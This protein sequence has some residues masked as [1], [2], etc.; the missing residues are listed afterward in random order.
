ML[1]ARW[2]SAL[3]GV[4]RGS[5]RS[6]P[7]S[8]GPALDAGLL[9]AVLPLVPG[10]RERL[11]AG[12][13][14]ADVGCGCGHALNLMA[15]AFPASRF[16]GWDVSDEALT[17]GRAEAERKGLANVRFEQR[18]A[19]TLGVSESFDF[20]TTFDAIHDQARPDL[21]LRR[22]W[23]GP[24]AREVLT[25]AWRSV[26][27]ARWLTTSACPGLP[28]MYAL[29]CMHCMTVSL[30]SG[31][32]GLGGHVGRTVGPPPSR[33]GR[34]AGAG[35]QA[36]PVRPFQQLLHC[37]QGHVGSGAQAGLEKLEP[38]RPV[39]ISLAA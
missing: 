16:V 6:A 12:I 27:R 29:S 39:G 37:H 38:P 36:A 26:P 4:T 9:E 28:G 14:V 32:V 1:L 5:R 35:R 8:V 18:D 3:L 34:S 31:G 25:C 20:I 15:E 10:L 24:C 7:N 19:A 33:R 13:D 17:A 23:P 22:N 21:V 30:A 11:R 2:G